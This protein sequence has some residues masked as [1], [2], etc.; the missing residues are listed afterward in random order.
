MA[1]LEKLELIKSNLDYLNEKQIDFIYEIMSLGKYPNKGDLLTLANRTT[2]EQ[3][4]VDTSYPLDLER[5][6]NERYPEIKNANLVMDYNENL[7]F[8][9]LRNINNDVV[10]RIINL[11]R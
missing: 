4:K 7:L 5:A 1:K 2:K 6:I 9:K 3:N 10:S 8:G 11:K